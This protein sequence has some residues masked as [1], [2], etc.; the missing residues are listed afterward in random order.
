MYTIGLLEATN[1]MSHEKLSLDFAGTTM[2]LVESD[3]VSDD[4]NKHQSNGFGKSAIAEAISYGIYGRL[5][6]TKGV[7]VPPSEL[8]MEGADKLTVD[9]HLTKMGTKKDICI[10]R[11]L[12]LDGK[13]T[14]SMTVD[15]VLRGYDKRKDHEAAIVSWLGFDFDVLMSRFL[16]PEN[17][18]FI[19][20]APAARFKFISSLLTFNWDKIWG[21]M[22]SECRKT[23]EEIDITKAEIAE[24]KICEAKASGVVEMAQYKE[25]VTVNKIEGLDTKINALATE[26][27]LIQD[28]TL[29]LETQEQEK[30][31]LLKS[32]EL[33]YTKSKN[34]LIKIR[35][36]ISNIKN[37]D[38][39]KEY[40]EKFQNVELVCPECT[41]TLC[42][43]TIIEQLTLK[44]MAKAAE[45][46]SDLEQAIT[47]AEQAKSVA[48]VAY[49]ECHLD[50]TDIKESL[51]S[52]KTDF[53][54]KKAELTNLLNSKNALEKEDRVRQTLDTEEAKRELKE[55]RAQL[56][57][58]E[59]LL[60]TKEK[61]YAAYQMLKNSSQTSS[62]ARLNSMSRILPALAAGV[63]NVTSHMFGRAINVGFKTDEQQLEIVCPELHITTMS[64]GERRSF[65]IAV[66]YTIQDLALKSSRNMIGFFIGD[67]IFDGLDGERIQA[68]VQLIKSL[69]IP[70]IFLITHREAARSLIE[71]SSDDIK[72]IRV[73]KNGPYST[74]KF[75]EADEL[76]VSDEVITSPADINIIDAPLN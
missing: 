71:H 33:E 76:L 52:H 13:K 28:E 40:E 18:S 24:L 46:V 47:I 45:N 53:R 44:D 59:K 56:K 23:K 70:Q 54:L 73:S 15:G 57:T 2:I 43:D 50:Y 67:E 1:F 12:S 55:A 58:L 68:A 5:L 10:S 31:K 27:N 60:I 49:E 25:T 7:R 72:I 14:F 64:T 29:K 34:L 3:S 38:I 17:T 21:E 74:A 65:D 35:E 19:A 20:L 30:S 42:P 41:H 48:K 66:A 69:P 16:T 6:R 62:P 36:R 26:A 9:L 63:S 4:E 32:K 61:Y 75:I 37:A 51:A 8:I 22:S 11:S 39:H